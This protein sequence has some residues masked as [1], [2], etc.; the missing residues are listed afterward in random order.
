MAD[1]L[2]TNNDA[3]SFT[4]EQMD[5]MFSGTLEA[6]MA[7]P[8]DFD[9]DLTE[10][11][12]IMLQDFEESWRQFILENGNFMPMGK[13]HESLTKMQRDIVATLEHKDAV[14]TELKRQLNFFQHSREALE[15]HYGQQ[16]DAANTYQS[17][18]H[19]HMQIQLDHVSQAKSLSQKI[20]PW[21][22]FLNCIDKAIPELNKTTTSTMKEKTF[23]PSARAMALVDPSGDAEDVCL[24][25]YRLD[26][27]LLTA[28]VKMLKQEL[29]KEEKMTSTLE[30]V[31]TL[32]SEHNIW[33]LLTKQQ[34][35]AAK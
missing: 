12:L 35:Q 1:P 4:C 8:D 28:Q 10:D 21:N 23:K 24:R 13:R 26:H 33:G 11:D 16:A 15:Q 19:D 34:E 18:M 2:Q 3:A 29:D 17:Q 7:N 6:M 20:V 14:E 22:H 32:L 30:I 9:L 31:G 25:A 5:V 27:A